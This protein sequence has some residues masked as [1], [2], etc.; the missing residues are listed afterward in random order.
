MIGHVED[1]IIGFVVM[2]L[3]WILVSNIGAWGLLGSGVS[4][5]LFVWYDW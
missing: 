1:F 5:A 3:L 2:A 4:G